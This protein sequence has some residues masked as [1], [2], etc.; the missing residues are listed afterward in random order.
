MYMF[1]TMVF[2]GFGF[3]LTQP[4]LPGIIISKVEATRINVVNYTY[5]VISNVAQ[6]IGASFALV[7]VA[8]FAAKGDA[9]GAITK[10]S[11]AF[12]LFAILGLLILRFI[13]KTV[14][15]IHQPKDASESQKEVS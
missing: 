15:G 1:I 6:R 10:T 12:A 14:E 4:L 2:L 9:G 11:L 8:L 13:P 5:Q 3:G 7:A